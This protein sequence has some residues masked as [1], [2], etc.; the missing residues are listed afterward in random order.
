[1]NILK[2]TV[3]LSLMFPPFKNFILCFLTGLLIFLMFVFVMF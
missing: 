3:P 2:K 1:M